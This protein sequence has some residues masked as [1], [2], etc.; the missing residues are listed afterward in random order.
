MARCFSGQALLGRLNSSFGETTE[1]TQ[2]YIVGTDHNFQKGHEPYEA[3]ASEFR[4][5]ISGVCRRTHIEAIGEE[6]SRE[7]LA[8][9]RV[10]KSVCEKSATELGL[11]HCLCD[12]DRAARQALG[13]RQENDIKLEG[14]RKN[15]KSKTIEREVLKEH[16]KREA[17]WLMWIKAC[18]YYPVLFVCGAN[19]VKSLASLLKSEGLDTKVLSKDWAPNKAMQPTPYSRG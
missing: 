1:M 17:I 11:K 5:Y 13:I 9:A 12:P 2:V 15:W 3:A 18:S 10:E 4:Q 8:E 7:A 14:L 6:M 19:H 16:R